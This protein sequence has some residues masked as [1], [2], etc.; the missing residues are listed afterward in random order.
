M[1]LLFVLFFAFTLNADEYALISNKDITHLSKNQIKAIYLKKLTMINGQ[2]IIP[3][4]LDARDPLREKFNQNLLHMSFE[5]L[6][7]YW[8]QEHYLGRRPPLSLKSQKSVKKFIK[9]VD[10]SIGYINMKNIDK[11]VTILYKWKD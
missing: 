9:N 1:K 5:R 8:T 4:N 10:G 11:N 6:K 3:I 7:S 2:T